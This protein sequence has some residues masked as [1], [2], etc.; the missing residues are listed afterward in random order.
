M[1]SSDPVWYE[2]L[3]SN[4]LKV[5]T[6]TD[7]LKTRIKT[8][9]LSSS[10]QKRS[11]MPQLAMISLG[12]ICSLFFILFVTKPSDLRDENLGQGQLSQP[13][14]ESEWQ[15]II[16]ARYPDYNNEVMFTHS[17]K[18]GEIM[19]FYSKMYK[20][21][22]H[23]NISLGVDLFKWE[24][25]QWNYQQGI[26]Y[27]VGDPQ[28]E[29]YKDKL[30]TANFGGSGKNPLFIGV[31]MDPQISKIQVVDVQNLKRTAQIIRN[32]DGNRYW[33][34]ALPEQMHGYVEVEGL[35]AANKAL[36]TQAYYIQ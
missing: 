35:D 2:A 17:N 7:E 31:V 29:G 12:I 3:Q 25:N 20:L 19:I 10:V 5:D 30:L 15:K 28:R 13:L 23:R 9:A 18:D 34:I 33:F 8:K 27:S 1:R 26:G 36:T 24:L 21:N 16:N 6:F 14:A 4:P 11:R 22:G 32:G